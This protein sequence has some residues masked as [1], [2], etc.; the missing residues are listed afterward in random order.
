MFRFKNIILL[1]F[2]CYTHRAHNIQEITYR[3]RSTKVLYWLSILIFYYYFILHASK[4]V[5]SKQE[6]VFSLSFPYFINK[7]F[8]KRASPKWWISL[9]RAAPSVLLCIVPVSAGYLKS[10]L[11]LRPHARALYVPL[12][13]I[14]F[15]FKVCV[16]PI[17]K[18]KH[19]RFW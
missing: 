8:G 9:N 14:E 6:Q 2:C 1:L 7:Y 12:S 10:A 16:I 15:I 5:P 4:L 18:K 11:Q 19:Q 13:L 3:Y 17:L